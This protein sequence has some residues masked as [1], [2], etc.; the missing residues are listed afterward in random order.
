MTR[1]FL[2][3]PCIAALATACSLPADVSARADAPMVAAAAA[4]PPPSM[5]DPSRPEAV[6]NEAAPFTAR[7]VNTF[8]QPWAM[9]FLP[10]GRALV[11]QKGGVLKLATIGS[12]SLD[13]GG[14]PAVSFKGQG[15][16]GD[17]VLHPKFAS[18]RLV[19]L[20]YVEAG[21]GGAK[22]AVV[23][24]Y[25]LD[26]TATSAALS[27]RKTIWTQNKISGD[28]HFGHRIAFGPDGKLWITSGERQKFDPAQDMKSNLG[29][30]VRL[31]DDGRV[32]SDNPFARQ[33]GVAAQ[34]WSLGHRNPLGIAFDGARQLWVVEM[35]PK[36]GDEINLIER[37]ANY[38]YP[39]V[40]NG[41]HYDG[42]VI[43]DHVTRP[44]FNAP[45][46]TWTPVI[47]PSS[48]V[49]YSGTRF[50]AWRG[51]G[52][53]GGLSSEALVRMEFNGDTAREAAR[54]PMG[55]RIREVEQ[56]PNGDLYVLEDGPGG[57]LL[58]LEPNG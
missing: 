5:S 54:Y 34:V 49:I 17:V 7:V 55:K 44:E 41:D 21:I 39:I 12:T 37:G 13:V 11:T 51:N 53:I 24:R 36:G 23:A 19:Y 40:S 9:T 33:G 50:P 25:R 10:D 3:A 42:R 48:L 31:F 18:N 29:K 15:G 26:A 1:R 22:G 4:K 32:P 57:R 46:T 58:R 16:L 35:G 14:V 56:A 28:G 20:S 30:V 47:S 38:G 27:D 8:D 45:E 2:L 6:R 43:P 52:L